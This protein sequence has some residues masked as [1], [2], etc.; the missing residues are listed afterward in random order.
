MNVLT[1]SMNREKPLS[2]KDL[3]RGWEKMPLTIFNHPFKMVR[4]FVG[5]GGSARGYF[6]FSLFLSSYK[7]KELGNAVNIIRVFFKVA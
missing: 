7:R 2:H 4:N 3:G 5:G 1:F 6:F